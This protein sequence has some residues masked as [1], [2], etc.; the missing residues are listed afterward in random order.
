[1]VWIFKDYI[2]TFG[3]NKIYASI[4]HIG[5]AY[6]FNATRD[7]LCSYICQS[8]VC[9]VFEICLYK[10]F[11]IDHCCIVHGLCFQLIVLISGGH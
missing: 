1:M 8:N 7:I 4:L 10:H 2:N 11:G 6:V 5:W 3:I 9:A